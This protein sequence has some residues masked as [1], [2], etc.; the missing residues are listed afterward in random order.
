MNFDD[1]EL[2]EYDR[3][4]ERIGDRLSRLADVVETIAL[5]R[6]EEQKHKGAFPSGLTVPPDECDDPTCR[7]AY[8][9]ARR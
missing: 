3:R 5:A 9:E 1:P 8:E 6:H 4:I 2:Q 7:A